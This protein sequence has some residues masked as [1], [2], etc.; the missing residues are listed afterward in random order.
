LEFEWKSVWV[1]T[2]T[3][4]F[5]I[6]TGFGWAIIDSVPVSERVFQAWV[7]LVSRQENFEHLHDKEIFDDTGS[8]GAIVESVGSGA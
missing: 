3:L 4:L 6:N 2:A 1:S 5:S 8:S 7:E